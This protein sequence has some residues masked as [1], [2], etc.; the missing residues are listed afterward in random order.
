MHRKISIKTLRRNDENSEQCK[1]KRHEIVPSCFWKTE[2]HISSGL[3]VRFVRF[4][5]MRWAVPLSI[6]LLVAT[7]LLSNSAEFSQGRDLPPLKLA[8]TDL[9][10]ILQKAHSLVAAAN[11]PSGGQEVVRESVK[12][13]VGGHEIEIPHFSMAS[14]VAFPREVFRFSYTYYQPDKAI[15]SV[16]L[17]FSDYSRRVSVSG[18]SADQVETISNLLEHDLVRYSTRI[19]GAR[20]RRVAGVLLLVTLLMSLMVSSAFWWNTRRDNALGMLGCS[21]FGLVLTLLV[22]WAR[23]LPGFALYQSYSPFLLIRYA[24]YIAFL[25]LV[26]TLAGI[27]LFYFLP[28]CRRKP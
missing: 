21:A 24:P 9:D 27:L 6:G 23:F 26:A 8:A 18:R 3:R 7:T 4:L 16:T 11:G 19:G 5:A 2:S 20:F 14:S 10:T 13:G 17:D 1:T 12:L 15:S 22:P 28:R 25:S